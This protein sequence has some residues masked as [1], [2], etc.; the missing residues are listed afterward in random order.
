MQ[1]CW[2]L[3]PEDRPNFSEIY[4]N[5]NAINLSFGLVATVEN[6]GQDA[7][8]NQAGSPDQA[9]NLIQVSLDVVSVNTIIRQTVVNKTMS[10]SNQYIPIKN[11]TFIFQNDETSSLN[12]NRNYSQHSVQNEADI[13]INSHENSREINIVELANAQ[14]V[15]R[16][17]A[18]TSEHVQPVENPVPQHPGEVSNF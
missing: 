18:S 10:F 7:S 15:P 12:H 13:E 6:Q 8:Q 3:R 1:S 4:Q 17:Q 11:T 16:S 9:Q 2:E 5:L 14:N